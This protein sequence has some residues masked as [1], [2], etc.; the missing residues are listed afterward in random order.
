MEGEGEILR[1][2]A[3]QS[4]GARSIVMDKVTGL[5]GDEDTLVVATDVRRMG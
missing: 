4:N 3:R 5:I 2:E 1:I